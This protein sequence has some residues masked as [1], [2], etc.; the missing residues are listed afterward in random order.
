V[1]KHSLYI[2]SIGPPRSFWTLSGSPTLLAT[3]ELVSIA[4]ASKCTP[5]QVLF[6]LAMMGGVTPLSGTKNEAHMEDAVAVSA[7]EL[8]DTSEQLK[9]LQD[10]IWGRR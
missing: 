9:A 7:L 4:E 2:P 10:I 3:P 1:P 6:K 5:S 8:K